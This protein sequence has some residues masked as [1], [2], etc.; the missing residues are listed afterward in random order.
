MVYTS[1]RSRPEVGLGV[2]AGRVRD[3]Q[4]LGEGRRGG[5][6]LLCGGY[7]PLSS[8]GS[9]GEGEVLVVRGGTAA[10]LRG[11]VVPPAAAVL[12]LVS[13]SP[14]PPLVGVVALSGGGGEGSDGSSDGSTLDSVVPGGRAEEPGFNLVFDVGVLVNEDQLV[15]VGHLVEVRSATEVLV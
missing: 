14:A 3:C 6:A 1:E 4:V 13:P 2:W 10:L 8:T 5:G 11:G 7:L 15:V 9:D 12:F